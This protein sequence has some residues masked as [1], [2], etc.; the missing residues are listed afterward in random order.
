MAADD[1]AP[2]DALVERRERSRSLGSWLHD[3]RIRHGL[4]LADVEHATRINRLY[5]EAI[6]DGRLE[7]LPAPVYA[8][9]FVR[10]YARLLGLDPSEAVSR[11]PVDLPPPIGLE[12]MPGMRRTQPP[13][14][15]LP[16]LSPRVM[17]LAAAV[18]V[19]LL[20]AV[21]I[22]PRLFGGGD[23]QPQVPAATAPATTTTQAPN[24]IGL[25]RD[26]AVKALTD[27]GLAPLVFEATNSAPAGQVFQ[28]SPPAG[29]NVPR[30]STVTVFVSQQSPSASATATATP[31]ATA[32]P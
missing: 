15:P 9:G 13:T 6:E 3:E 5:L 20:F 14:V 16:P 1:H 10:S 28:Q 17:A 22:V 26:G 30:G 21:L 4:S 25:T 11:M 23:E 31:T 32:R 19:V 18:G 12:P 29:S 24:L 2:D 27:A 8:R 7:S